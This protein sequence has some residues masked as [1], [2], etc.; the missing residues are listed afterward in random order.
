[1]NREK[2]FGSLAYWNLEA[3]TKQIDNFRKLF[4]LGMFIFPVPVLSLSEYYCAQRYDEDWTVC[5]L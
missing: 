3:R 5:L 4:P 2:L 1:M